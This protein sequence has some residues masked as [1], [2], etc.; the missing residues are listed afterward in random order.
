[1]LCLIQHK[2]NRS[3]F[4]LAVFAAALSLCFPF[5][6]HAESK[7][8]ARVRRALA[9]QNE[10]LAWVFLTDKGRYETS[11]PVHDLVSAASLR[12]RQNA[13]PS[14]SLV[15]YTDLPLDQSY[16]DE[17][18]LHVLNVRHRSKWFNALSV[19]VSQS[20]L[21][22][23][24]S[25]PFVRSIDLVARSRR[26]P[27]EHP[28][29]KLEPAGS[30]PSSS[31]HIY[32]F[33]YGP[34]LNQLQLINVPAV[35]ATG[36]FGQSVLVG[37][38][39]NGFRLLEHEAFDSLT[40]AATYDFVDHKVS[41]VPNNPEPGFGSH[42]I[43]TLSNIA[44]FKSGQLIG[45]AFKAQYVL[46]RTEN[47]SSETPIEEDNWVAAIEWADSLGVQV[48][49]TSLGY[50]T[51]D[52]PYSSWTWENMDGNTTMITRAADMAVSKGIVVVNSAGNNGPHPSRNT[53]N[54][55]ADGD[56]VIAVGAVTGTGVR[57]GFSSVGPTV[58]G[59]IK[60]DVMAQG[61]SIISASGSDPSA[62][63]TPQGTSHSCPLVAGVIALM[64]HARPDATPMQ[65]RSALRATA[66]QSTSPDNLNGWGIV[67]AEDAIRY[68]TG[69]PPVEI[70]T[71]FALL[72]NYP[73]PFNGTTRIGYNLREAAQVRLVVFDVLGRE[74]R[75]LLDASLSPSPPEVSYA[76][77]DGTDNAG[78][79]VASG[80]Y[81]YRLEAQGRPGNTFR[82][83][84]K[85]VLL[86]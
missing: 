49:S 58:D 48:T 3:V 19:R 52:P 40:V 38:F 24:E 10:V 15:D 7:I 8:T 20:Q 51:Y 84:K 5:L 81:F 29:E 26:S 61:T 42:G 71:S 77:W 18:S 86:R 46:A 72:Q 64:L 67:N 85:L 75:S 23:L 37:V 39:D 78:R 82:G 4:S 53:L 9:N 35:H 59:R 79:Q 17:L 63:I 57:A 45:P 83:T 54:A 62:Y 1:M 55:P 25:L 47:D 80:I 6:T 68:L 50:L 33:D 32:S 66:S 28:N 74:I 11:S 60:P 14:T 27:D 69:E 13:L 65:I 34:S 21:A 56:S 22:A 2:L 76:T 44:G 12:R 41:V 30:A 70:P 16:V 36:N 73:N 43:T 31:E